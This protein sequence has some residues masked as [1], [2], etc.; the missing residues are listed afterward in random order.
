MPRHVSLKKLMK[1]RHI[2]IHESALRSE[3]LAAAGSRIAQFIKHLRNALRARR[4]IAA[5]AALDDWM[6]KDIGLSR[7]DVHDVK[8]QSFWAFNPLEPKRRRPP[9]ER[10]LDALAH[11]DDSD[12]CKLSEAGQRLR[13]EAQRPR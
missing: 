7:G 13:R 9:G 12:I 8:R 5:L 2:Q 4:Q 3:A 11:L 10:S 6:L 1:L